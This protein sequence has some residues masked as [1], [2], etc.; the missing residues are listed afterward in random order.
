[1]CNPG[2]SLDPK[3]TKITGIK[4]EDLKDK[5]PFIAH[6]K[7]LSHWFLGQRSLAAHNL[8]FDRKVLRYELERIDKLTKFP[9]AF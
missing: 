6:Y 7:E 2:H 4:D 1:M 3:I 9:L 8:P 5:K